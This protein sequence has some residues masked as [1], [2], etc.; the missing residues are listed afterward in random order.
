MSYRRPITGPVIRGNHPPEEE[1]RVRARRLSRETR[2]KLRDQ[3][4]AEAEQDT[5]PPAKK[6]TAKKTTAKKPSS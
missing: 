6:T 1:T 2:L 5:P 4:A 3:D